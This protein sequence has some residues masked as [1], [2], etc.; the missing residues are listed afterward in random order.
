MYHS[1]QTI[2][3]DMKC[4][5]RV[6]IYKHTYMHARFVLPSPFM[7]DWVY[8]RFSSLCFVRWIAYIH[9]RPCHKGPSNTWDHLCFVMAFGV[10]GPWWI[11]VHSASPHEGPPH[12]WPL[13]LLS[14][15]HCH[16]MSYTY[17]FPYFCPWTF[18]MDSWNGIVKPKSK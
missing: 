8:E 17:R 11:L 7:S 1:Y 9:W 2:S 13:T 6:Y 10:L 18:G 16:Q 4:N 3:H 12:R 5:T 14:G 15:F